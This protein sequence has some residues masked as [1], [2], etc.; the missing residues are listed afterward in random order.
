MIDPALEQYYDSEEALRMWHT[1]LQCVSDDPLRRPRMGHVVL[2][3]KGKQP[4]Y[5]P[6]PD[7]R[8]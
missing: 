5:A 3:L 4:A 6:S 2:M 1:A 7:V 8:R